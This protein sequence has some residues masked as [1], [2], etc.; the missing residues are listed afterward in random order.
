M[1]SLLPSSTVSTLAPLYFVTQSA[2]FGKG[3][4]EKIA[5]RVLNSCTVSFQL[6]STNINQPS[7]YSMSAMMLQ[8]DIN[9]RLYLWL[10]SVE[11]L[12]ITK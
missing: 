2:L 10:K 9:L 7:D 5:N 8:N 11:L 12:N 6:K 1:Y 4:V 3:L